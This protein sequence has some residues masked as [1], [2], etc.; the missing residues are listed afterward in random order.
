MS[1]STSTPF[2]KL[3]AQNFYHEQLLKQKNAILIF[4]NK[5]MI[6]YFRKYLA[7][8]IGKSEISPIIYTI[9][10]FIREHIKTVVADKLTLIFELFD[11]YKTAV[12]QFNQSL[13]QFYN[14]ADTLLGDFNELDNYLIS[15]DMIFTNIKNIT[16]LSNSYD[17]LSDEQI[18]ILQQFWAY[19][20]QNKLS[21]DKEKYLQIWDAI[22]K[23]YQ[24]FKKQ[25]LIK[26]IAYSGMQL[27]LFYEKLMTEYFI[28]KKYYLVGFNA[29]NEAHLR[30]FEIMGKNGNLQIYWDTDDYYINNQIQEAG[31]FLRKNIKRL[32]AYSIQLPETDNIRHKIKHIETYSIPGRVAQAQFMAG[33]LNKIPDEN[34]IGIILPDE[35]MLF[36]ILHNMPSKTRRYNITMGYP[37]K[38]TQIF[39]F[40][41]SFF[42]LHQYRIELIS[43]KEF[44]FQS[45]YLKQIIDNPE[46]KKIINKVDNEF[47][48]RVKTNTKRIN[49]ATLNTKNQ[50]F[51][52]HLF[53]THTSTENFI[54]SLRE[55]LYTLF[56]EQKTNELNSQ[57]IESEFIIQSYNTVNRLGEQL[58][59]PDI[60]LLMAIKICFQE[61]NSL[62]IPFD[63]E[64]LDQVQIMGLME[65]RSIDFD[66]VVLIDANEGILPNVSNPNSFIPQM[67][68]KAFGMPVTAYQDAIF[69]YLFYRLL[70]KS[71]KTYILYNSLEISNGKAEKSR[72]L[73]Q[74]E[75]ELGV[76]S[77]QQTLFK[78]QSFQESNIIIE[79]NP[80]IRQKLAS[81]LSRSPQNSSKKISTTFI[82]QFLKCKLAFFFKYVAGLKAEEDEEFDALSGKDIGQMLH[83]SLHKSYLQL[84]ENNHIILKPDSL[85][86]LRSHIDSIVD[87]ELLSQYQLDTIDQISGDQ[88]L[89]ADI[90]K[91]YAE[92][93]FKFDTQNA[94]PIE[95]IDMEASYKYSWPVEINIEEE[96]YFVNFSGIFDRVDKAEYTRI[97]DYKTGN[98]EKSFIAI[99]QLFSAEEKNL[100]KYKEIFQIVLYSVIYYKSTGVMPVPL[101]YDVRKMGKNFDPH[102]Y[103]SGIQYD[104]KSIL[105]DLETIEY[106]LIEL[107][108]GIFHPAT[109]FS[110]TDE[111]K[112]CEYCDFK[113]ICKR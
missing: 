64:K 112:N 102:I 81:Y 70:Q 2:L 14:Y 18:E 98:T 25:L 20:N 7:E 103:K 15:V 79:N 22:P 94:N 37:F 21:N 57:N 16:E 95:I 105:E 68:R 113:Q 74:I 107:L 5:R 36:P 53:N 67:I 63:G 31:L 89:S 33:L 47:Y 71:K 41:T 28:Q 65:S 46:I 17:F 73:N 48:N 56:S 42:K 12:P 38:N 96:A 72:Y 1:D 3:V 97:I 62:S 35:K 85:N 29:L 106:E 91:K 8:T 45:Y 32:M 110:Q 43:Q 52:S 90:V 111:I 9:D 82:H 77:P 75:F 4:P 109:A 51:L 93:V 101:I 40:L 6:A 50:S 49:P 24:Q 55:I 13:D 11:A 39:Q 88:K 23:I 59:R 100:S 58:Q 10:T 104:A 34:N 69:A 99:N 54:N 26:N 30:I 108:S 60:T 92:I 27:R 61:I 80:E 78:I 19:F 66:Y 76:N 44:P 84:K 87:N 86:I 83:N